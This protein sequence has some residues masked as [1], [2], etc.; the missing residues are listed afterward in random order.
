MIVIKTVYG[1]IN[2][3]SMIIPFLVSY[4][5]D[6]D[7]IRSLLLSLGNGLRELKYRNLRK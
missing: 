3:I 1:Y 5:S 6:L 7:F 2:R 4:S